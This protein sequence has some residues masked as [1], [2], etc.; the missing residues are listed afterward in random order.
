MLAQLLVPSGCTLE[1]LTDVESPLQVAEQVAERQPRL[2]IFSHV[3]PEGLYQARYL[4][5][6]V[7]AHCEGLPL[8]IG[9]W[10]EIP[11]A[12]SAAERL[13]GAGASHVVFTLEDARSRILKTLFP[14][15]AY[16]N[17]VFSTAGSDAS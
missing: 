5:R 3:P 4:V 6:R 14:Q 7:R 16:A 8:V 17:G 12:T 9:R 13:A 1:I 15:G 2:V 11:G 10:G